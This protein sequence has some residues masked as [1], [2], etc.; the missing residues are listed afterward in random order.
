MAHAFDER[1]ICCALATRQRIEREGNE[2]MFGA[3]VEPMAEWQNRLFALMA[4]RLALCEPSAKLITVVEVRAALHEAKVGDFVP[5]LDSIVV[6]YQDV[7]LAVDTFERLMAESLFGELAA[8]CTPDAVHYWIEAALNVM[9][10]FGIAYLDDLH[11]G[12]AHDAIM[13]Q[14]FSRITFFTAAESAKAS[15]RCTCVLLNALEN[16]NL[17]NFTDLD[18]V[19]EIGWGLIREGAWPELVEMEQRWDRIHEQEA[20]RLWPIAAANA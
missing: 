8:R 6:E 19:A 15:I 17:L 13:R 7:S 14:A 16:M 18:S 20:D 3:P 4:Q 5:M 9:Q 11:D 2:R 12:D 10:E 1:T